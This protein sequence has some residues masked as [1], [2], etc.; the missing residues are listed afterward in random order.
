M[1]EY[2]NSVCWVNIVI[3]ESF[4]DDVAERH[5]G[6][7]IHLFHNIHYKCGKWNKT[8]CCLFNFVLVIPFYIIRIHR[9]FQ[10]F[11]KAMMNWLKLV[12]LQRT[13][14]LI[15]VLHRV[16]LISQNPW[17]QRFLMSFCFVYCFP[18]I[19]GD[20]AFYWK[21]YVIHFLLWIHQPTHTDI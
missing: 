8:I 12:S 19:D 3:S 20:H 10:S 6:I 4:V 17:L 21:S 15:T 7:A 14:W 5:C 11:L 9:Y 18:E 13:K 2:F 16:Y 1:T